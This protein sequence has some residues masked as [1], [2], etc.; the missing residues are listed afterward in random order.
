LPHRHHFVV[1]GRRLIQAA[2]LVLRN[3][4]R[5][6]T[7]EFDGDDLV[8]LVQHFFLDLLF[9]RLRLGH[10]AR[11]QQSSRARRANQGQG[12]GHHKQAEQHVIGTQ[13]Q[14]AAEQTGRQNQAARGRELR[15]Q[16]ALGQRPQVTAGT[17]HR[18]RRHAGRDD[19]DDCRQAHQRPHPSDRT[20]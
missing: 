20:H 16:H 13:Q 15:V 7:A 2:Q 4:G 17:D 6:P 10:A 19:R 18:P 5:R 1:L 11:R 12:D 3:V 9:H 14:A 8:E